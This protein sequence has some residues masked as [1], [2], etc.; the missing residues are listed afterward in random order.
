MLGYSRNFDQHT[1]IHEKLALMG[2]D[3]SLGFGNVLQHSI[4]CALLFVSLLC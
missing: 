2:Y 1:A 4:Q 3:C